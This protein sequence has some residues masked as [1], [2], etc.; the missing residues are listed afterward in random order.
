MDHY[1]TSR[2]AL[3]QMQETAETPSPYEYRVGFRGRLGNVVVHDGNVLRATIESPSCFNLE[4]YANIDHWVVELDKWIEG[5][6]L[7]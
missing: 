6:L 4:G 2:F 1:D 5:I 7:Q 3:V